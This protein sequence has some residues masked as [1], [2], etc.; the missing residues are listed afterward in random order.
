VS[1]SFNPLTGLGLDEIFR[2]TTTSANTAN[3]SA[4]TDYL[5]DA[6]HSTLAL[7]DTSG[8]I[9][10]KYSYEPYGATSVY[11]TGTDTTPS[12]NTYQYTGREND[13]NGL[14]Y[15]RN[16]F[17]LP[18]VGAFGSE[19]P[20]GFAAGQNLNLYVGGNP[21]FYRD[22]TGLLNFIAGG[23]GNGVFIGSGGEGSS[24]G[25]V[26][27]GTDQWG[28][29][30]SSGSGTDWSS[31]SQAGFGAMGGGFFGFVTGDA[32]NI[33]GPFQNWNL[34]IPGTN[35]SITAYFN[36]NGNLVGGAIGYGPGA[37][38]TSTSTNTTIYP[39]DSNTQCGCG[40]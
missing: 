33:S 3:P 26:N 30:T 16:R 39:G 35:F 8:T 36:G 14:Y 29:F 23:G 25:Y 10:T 31:S 37:G 12:D 7:T 24:G 32:C 6:L 21:V 5:T 28:G 34:A 17:L 40:Q 9:K 38:F 20:V 13:Q 2:R 4:T 19:D 11:T 27:F 1:E 22:P 15:Y 18:G